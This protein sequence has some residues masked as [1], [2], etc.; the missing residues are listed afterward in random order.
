MNSQQRREAV[1]TSALEWLAA[2]LASAFEADVILQRLN[3]SGLL[4]F[5][6]EK[7]ELAE[8]L[9][10]LKGSEFVTAVHHPHGAT[11]FYQ[12]TAAGVR[13]HERG[14]LSPRPL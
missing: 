5:N 4:D 3:K 7:D 13:A 12:A 11:L 14:T 9:A 10:F 6:A 1:R 8:A 2:R